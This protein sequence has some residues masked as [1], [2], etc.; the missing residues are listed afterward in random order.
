VISPPVRYFWNLSHKL[1]NTYNY[2]KETLLVALF[3]VSIVVK[4]FQEDAISLGFFTT[5]SS[6]L[7]DE[8]PSYFRVSTSLLPSQFS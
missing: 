7:T 1:G 5:L 4:V 8:I 6:V 2:I 3:T